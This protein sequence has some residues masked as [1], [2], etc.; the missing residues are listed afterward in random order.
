MG[1]NFLGLFCATKECVPHCLKS[2]IGLVGLY[3]WPFL[4][5]LF[6][7]GRI[8]FQKANKVCYADMI[9]KVVFPFSSFIFHSAW[10]LSKKAADKE[11]ERQKLLSALARKPSGISGTPDNINR[12]ATN[13]ALGIAAVAMT[14]SFAPANSSGSSKANGNIILNKMAFVIL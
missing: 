6:A 2:V 13:T 7:S 5:K 9:S 4:L 14:S 1:K 10:A 8:H 3:F 11:R 12:K